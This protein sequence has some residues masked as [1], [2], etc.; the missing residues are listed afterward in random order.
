MCV[1]RAVGL[2]TYPTAYRVWLDAGRCVGL[3]REFDEQQ[4][5][6]RGC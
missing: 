4:R 3:C 5:V 2:S 1:G 6:F